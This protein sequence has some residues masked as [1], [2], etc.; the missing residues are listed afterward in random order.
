MKNLIIPTNRQ[1]R[2][3]NR[4][5]L[6]SFKSNHEKPMGCVIVC[7][8]YVVAE[9]FNRLKTHPVQFKNDKKV[10][11]YSPHAKMHAEVDA[12]VKSKNFDLT[13]CEIY[14]FRQD[15]HGNIA[16]SK[17]CISC[18]PALTIAGIRHIFYTSKEGYCYYD[19]KLV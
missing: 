6:V 9:G 11:Y 1:L 18:M 5:K 17:P 13:N 14:L 2:F 19:N 3:F 10:N 4:A 12:L 16:E 7:G 15:K 8:N